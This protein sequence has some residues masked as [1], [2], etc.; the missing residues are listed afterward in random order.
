MAGDEV[1]KDEPLG[2]EAGGE[3]EPVGE[4]ARGPAQ[5][6]LRRAP[7][8]S[9]VDLAHGKGS[10]RLRHARLLLHSRTKSGRAKAHHRANPRPENQKARG[11]VPPG[12][13]PASFVGG[14]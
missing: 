8:E 14:G 3:G 13:R 7:G 12:L 10:R 11:L 1:E 2:P 5:D 9:L 4:A 6:L